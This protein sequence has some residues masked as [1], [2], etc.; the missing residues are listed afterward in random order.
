MLFPVRGFCFASS[1]VSLLC[2]HHDTEQLSHNSTSTGTQEIQ[3][4]SCPAQEHWIKFS[5]YIY[6]KLQLTIKGRISHRYAMRWRWIELFTIILPERCHAWPWAHLAMPIGLVLLPS[7][8][9]H[10]SVIFPS[11][12]QLSTRAISSSTLPSTE[13]FHLPSLTCAIAFL[14]IV[15]ISVRVRPRL[16]RINQGYN[17]VDIVLHLHH[18]NFQEVIGYWASD[19][20]HLAL[21][22]TYQSRSKSLWRGPLVSLIVNLNE[23]T[24]EW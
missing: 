2:W 20:V 19:N 18:W 7:L 4:Y 23:A 22:L 5:S 24:P 9:I 10:Q 6:N 15:P 11:P 1:K 8:P 21:M 17:A 14:S 13:A 3:Q 12:Q 16:L